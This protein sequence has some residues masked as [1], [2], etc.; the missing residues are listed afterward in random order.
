MGNDVAHVCA[1]FGFPVKLVDISE[2]A[3]VKGLDTISKN[4]D[5]QINKGKISSEDKAATLAR[6]ETSTDY[7]LFSNCDLV[8]EAA[9]ENEA[10][11]KQIL[12][13]LCPVLKQ[14]A[15]IASNTS[16][17]SITRLVAAT[18][19]PA[20]FMGMH[21][22]NPVPVMALVRT[23][24]W[25]CYRQRDIRHDSQLGRPYGKDIGKCR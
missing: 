4:L 21:F 18:D 7:G 16:S 10:V 13:K 15:Y 19:R 1:I 17:I 9:T 24:S 3:L 2:S 5:R 11:K 22:M 20:R 23:D 14:N 8:I 6:I 25:Y 12:T